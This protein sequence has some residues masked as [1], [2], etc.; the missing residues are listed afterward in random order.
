MKVETVLIEKENY[1]VVGKVNIEDNLYYCLISEKDNKNFIIR[2][3]IEENNKK[4]LLGLS[5]EN[6]YNLVVSEYRQQMI[7]NI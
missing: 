1:C 7:N 2:K 6:E 5:D 4:L 3:L